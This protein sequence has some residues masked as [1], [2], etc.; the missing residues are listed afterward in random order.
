M[1]LVC[2][3]RCSKR[4]THIRNSRVVYFTNKLQFFWDTNIN[5]KNTASKCTCCYFFLLL[6]LSFDINT[7]FMPSIV[8]SN[9]D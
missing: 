2:I 8:V 5:I 4:I 3:K 6:L 9:F 1:K 7:L